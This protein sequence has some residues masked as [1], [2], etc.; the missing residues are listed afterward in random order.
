MANAIQ[1]STGA[2]AGDVVTF[3]IRSPRES[4]FIYLDYT[5]GD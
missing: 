5:K 3:N 2:V 4:V 1:S